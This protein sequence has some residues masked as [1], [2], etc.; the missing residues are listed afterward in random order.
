MVV[1]AFTR[2]V[3]C[4]PKSIL[5]WRCVFLPVRSVDIL[6]C[7]LD[8]LFAGRSSAWVAVGYIFIVGSIV[9][10]VFIVGDACR[11]EMI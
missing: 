3:L 5:D 11:R 6:G 7:S 2:S 8:F 10:V 1:V 9:T 4:L